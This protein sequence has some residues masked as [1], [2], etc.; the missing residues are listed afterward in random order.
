MGCR[1]KLSCRLV[2]VVSPDIS[3]AGQF[4]FKFIEER[5]ERTREMQKESL[6]FFLFPSA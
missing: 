2:I 3:G 1:A 4:V 6:L 5:Y